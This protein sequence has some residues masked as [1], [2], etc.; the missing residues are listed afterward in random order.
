MIL[1][2]LRVWKVGIGPRGDRTRSGETDGGRERFHVCSEQGAVPGLGPREDPLQAPGFYHRSS[3]PIVCEAGLE[4]IGGGAAP[5]PPPE[6]E[7]CKRKTAESAIN[8]VFT[9]SARPVK[10]LTFNPRHYPQRSLGFG[11]SS[12]SFQGRAAF[13]HLHQLTAQINLSPQDDNQP[14]PQTS[15]CHS[16]GGNSQNSWLNF[17]ENTPQHVVSRLV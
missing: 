3:L 16:N 15:G 4:F 13:R 10:S 6:H 11:M 5:P 12:S 9:A 7:S 8:T 14:P 2:C 1:I 17:R